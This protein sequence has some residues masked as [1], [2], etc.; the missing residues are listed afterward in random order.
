[1]GQEGP[2]E[3]HH[4]SGMIA[5]NP[6]HAR[7]HD[8]PSIKQLGMKEE[9]LDPFCQDTPLT[10]VNFRRGVCNVCY[11]SKDLFNPCLS[12]AEALFLIF[13]WKRAK[14]YCPY[15]RDFAA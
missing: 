11:S 3:R 4:F 1:L 7:K 5:D 13:F 10:E 15:H 2:V 14:F 12:D 8:I 6:D 9:V